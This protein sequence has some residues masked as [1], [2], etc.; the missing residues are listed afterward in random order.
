MPQWRQYGSFFRAM[1]VSIR[2]DSQGI[3]I[4]I[5][6]YQTSL[7]DHAGIPVSPEMFY[8]GTCFE[9]RERIKS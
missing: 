1:A 9:N 2:E 4:G 8:K 5:K 7:A 3:W 6:G